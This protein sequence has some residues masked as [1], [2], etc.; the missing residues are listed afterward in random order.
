MEIRGAWNSGLVQA[1]YHECIIAGVARLTAGA[2]AAPYVTSKSV[3][4]GML[5][6]PSG[7]RGAH[8]GACGS[9][10][11]RDQTIHRE[12]MYQAC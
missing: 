7:D 11:P 12:A 6:S 5:R 10:G 1:S 4:A 9:T 3:I 8:G 2:R